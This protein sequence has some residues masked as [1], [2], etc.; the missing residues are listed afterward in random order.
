MDSAAVARVGVIRDVNAM[1]AESR[2]GTDVYMMKDRNVS[3]YTR[4]D[5]RKE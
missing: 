2:A 1:A 5:A 4:L 3:I